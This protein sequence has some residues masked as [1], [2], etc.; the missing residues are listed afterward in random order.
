MFIPV[1]TPLLDGNEKKYLAECIDSGWISSEGPFVKEFEKCFSAYHG[2]AEGIAVSNGSAALDVAV[3]SLGLKHGDEVIIPASTIIS[4]AQCLVRLGLKP[5]LVDSEPDT[6]N[7][8]VRQIE[9][10]ITS[11]TKAI[12]IVHLFG[13]PVDV[14]SV[15]Q[16]AKAYKL[17]IIEDAAQAIGLKYKDRICGSFG[18][19]STFSFYSNKNVTTGEGGMILTSDTHLANRCRSFRNLCFKSSKRFEHDELGWNYRMTNLQAA[20][21]LAQ[22]ESLER[23]VSIKK[24]I[25]DRYNMAF[26]KHLESLQLPLESTPY[27]ENNYW[28]YGFCS[29][30][31]SADIWMKSLADNG[32]GTRPFFW[33]IHRQP[34]FAQMGLFIGENYP[35]AEYM[36]KNGFYIPSGLGLSEDDQQVVIDCVLAQTR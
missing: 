11:K 10:K 25:G 22:F 13:L 17:K 15:M 9:R 6:W 23:H 1:S 34:I 29:R 35:V 31:E 18:D 27:A 32:V 19:V 21:G 28:V 7:M 8:D 2:K 20:V 33:P 5:V 4:C 26:N 12:M 14:D 16:L 36:A 30:D 3:A 24:G